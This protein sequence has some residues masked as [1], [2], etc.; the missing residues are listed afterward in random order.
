MILSNAEQIVYK[1]INV[2]E[3]YF[4]KIRVWPIEQSFINIIGNG[5]NHLGQHN[6]YILRETVIT[7]DFWIVK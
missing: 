3:I 4:K 1:G 7:N 6:N 2:K 5:D